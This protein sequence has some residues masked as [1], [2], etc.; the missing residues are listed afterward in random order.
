MALDLVVFSGPDAVAMRS[1]FTVRAKMRDAGG[2]VDVVPT[3]VY[4]RLDDE[5]GAVLTE[6]TPLP[7]P[8]AATMAVQLT[9]EQ[10]RIVV[11]ARD[12]ERKQLTLMVDRGLPT[13][14]VAAWSYLVRNLGWPS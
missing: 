13:Q 12:A 7:G 14:F 2:F 8:M 6:W 9:G 10:N 3:N 4:Y 5:S 11:G 1:T